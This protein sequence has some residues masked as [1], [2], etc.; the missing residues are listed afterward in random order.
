M[1][2]IR[3]ITGKQIIDKSNP[4]NIFQVHIKSMHGDGD[5]YSESK[6]DV[7]NVNDVIKYL[8][9]FAAR[10]T[11]IGDQ[12]N[13]SEVLKAAEEKAIELKLDSNGHDLWL[14]YVG[15]DIT[16][17]QICAAP[18]ELWVTYFNNT[19]IEFEYQVNFNGKELSR[20]QE[21]NFKPR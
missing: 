16:N 9:L 15:S 3:L 21:H 20:L 11:M 14:T 8:I 4:I 17:E 10:W 6:I 19:G 12:Y 7:D 2:I 18:D 13:N 5:H 1:D